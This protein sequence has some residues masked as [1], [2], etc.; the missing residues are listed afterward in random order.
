MT[1]SGPKTDR[2]MTTQTNTD[3]AQSR[4]GHYAKQA[5][6]EIGAS[7]ILA[8]LNGLMLIV[9]AWVLARTVRDLVFAKTPVGGVLPELALFLGLYAL[10]A[11]LT[12][13]SE[14]KAFAAGA[15]I[16]TAVRRD[17]LDSLASRGPAG[18]GDERSGGIV[19]GFIEGVE[20]LHNYYALTLPSRMTAVFLPLAIFVTILPIDVISA[21]TLLVTAPLIPI[22]MIWIGKGAEKLSQRQWRRMTA[23]SGHFLD[24]I[25]G[26][27]TLKLF[28]ASRRQSKVIE[29]VADAFRQDTM[30]VLRVAFLSSLALEFFAT[31]SIAMIA[32]LIGFRL[33]WGQLAF[34]DGFF[35]L[36]LAPEFYLPLRRMGTHY[37]AKMEAIGAMEKIVQLLDSPSPAARAGITPPVAPVTIRFD[38][39]S[40]AYDPARPVLD[41]VSFTVHAGE[42]LALAGPS[43]G[44]KTT[45]LNLILGFLTPQAGQIWINDTPL[46][47]L[48]RWQWLQSLSWMAQR[49]RLFPGTID[50]NIR[51]A[52]AIDDQALDTLVA[53]TGVA[54]FRALPTGENGATLSG[55]QMQRVA[56]ARALARQAP[57]LLMDEPTAHLDPVTEQAIQ[58]AIARHAAGRTIIFA[59]HRQASLAQANRILTVANGTVSEGAVRT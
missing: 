47:Q 59:A 54:A 43:G 24:M 6:R 35:V 46:D 49:P 50:D 52:G 9:A 51:M 39:V 34:V 57:L 53:D 28:N 48:D 19:N 14:R 37:H 44:G 41:N 4:L 58:D 40:F 21:L 27:T 18:I 2:S 8:S 13:W 32:V 56:L 23:M 15:K 22:F 45:I 26:L 16:R 31:V 42:K 25:Q 1:L 29:R 55:G 33:L 10:R 38:Q 5:R 30:A 11:F 12:G 17:L 36:L 7:V 3:P 20:A